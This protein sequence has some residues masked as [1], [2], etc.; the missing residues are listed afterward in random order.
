MIPLDDEKKIKEEDIQV[1]EVDEKS[2]TTEE[3]VSLNIPSQKVSEI[4]EMFTKLSKS[5]HDSIELFKASRVHQVI[6]TFMEEMEKI[7][8]EK[9]HE[10]NINYLKQRVERL[11]E[12]G[13]ALVVD[14][15]GNMILEDDFLEIDKLTID[16]RMLEFYKENEY[17]NLQVLR[18]YINERINPIWNEQLNDAV[19]LFIKGD[20]KVVI[21]FVMTLIEAE[22]IRYSGRDKFGVRLRNDFKKRIEKV[23][24]DYIFIATLLVDE[25]IAKI[26]DNKKEDEVEGELLNRNLV[27]HGKSNPDMWGEIEF[28]KILN[29]VGALVMLDDMFEIEKVS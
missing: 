18:K 24:D 25:L 19:R 7:D 20:Y 8:P 22:M 11:S 14:V 10:E 4:V 16:Q 29:L 1:P 15:H 28:L 27:L 13:W 6:S 2:E 17:E 23:D 5:I 3:K 21:P 26:F 12:K 9:F